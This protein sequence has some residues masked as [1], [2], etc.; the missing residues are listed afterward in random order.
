MFDS[1]F[2]PCPANLDLPSNLPSNTFMK[3]TGFLFTALL[4]AGLLLPAHAELPDNISAP[5]LGELYD[6]GRGLVTLT[7]PTG[8]FIN[9]TSG[10]MPAGSVTVQYCFFLPGGATVKPSGHGFLGSYGVTDSL[11]VGVFGLYANGADKFSAG[12]NARYRFLKD[13]GPNSF[14][15]EFSLVGY[16]RF[17][18]ADFQTFWG[19]APTAFKRFPVAQNGVLRSVGVHA[20]VRYEHN[21]GT[22]DS[23]LFNGYGGLELELPANVYLVGE[24]STKESDRGETE[25][26]YSFGSQWRNGLLNISIAG[27][28]NGKT[29]GPK[30]FF[31]VGLQGQF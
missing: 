26:P 22:A 7:G 6:G 5:T 14:I 31:G 13:G 30:F 8:L 20:G 4:S 12:P 19:L 27:I 9:P 18:E 2:Q 17:G 28:Q 3:S 15:P 24:I 29:N 25:T 21:D 1:A 10:T 16:S 23:N 11:E